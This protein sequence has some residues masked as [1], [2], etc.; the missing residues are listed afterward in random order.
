ML[1]M[2]CFDMLQ[3]KSGELQF[4]LQLHACPQEG[5]YQQ[6][7]LDIKCV[8][9]LPHSFELAVALQRISKI[10][11]T[12]GFSLPYYATYTDP[13]QLNYQGQVSPIWYTPAQNDI[14]Y[15][16]KSKHTIPCCSQPYCAQLLVYVNALLILFHFNVLH[17]EFCVSSGGQ[18]RRVSF[19]LALLQEPPLLVLDEPT[20]GIDPLLR[21][22]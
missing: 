2:I 8:K 1:H 4:M 22:R 9:K 18:K 6:L 7:L 10:K 19:A 12:L 17:N 14:V 13:A 3:G 15:T 16:R 11:D 21:S 20:V 5:K